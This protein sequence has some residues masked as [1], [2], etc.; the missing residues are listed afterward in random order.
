MTTTD[1]HGGQ[2]PMDMPVQPAAPQAAQPAAAPATR[3]ARRRTAQRK[4][5]PRSTV[6]L[7]AVA[8]TGAAAVIVTGLAVTAG[9]VAALA[10]A[11]GVPMTVAARMLTRGN[12]TPGRRTTTRRPGRRPGGKTPALK[13]PVMPKMR[14]AGGG[15][16]GTKTATRPPGSSKAGPRDAGS[17]PKKTAFASPGP[18]GAKTRSGPAGAGTGMPKVTGPRTP[19]DGARTPK[20]GARPAAGANP[21]RSSAGTP[22]VASKRTGANATRGG[23]PTG[24][25]RRPAQSSSSTPGTS[26]VR[27]VAE[28]RAARRATPA[29]PTRRAPQVTATHASGGVPDRPTRRGLRTP[30]TRVGHA[31]Q[32]KRL[33]DQEKYLAWFHNRP[34][35]VRQGTRRA[36]TG[37]GRAAKTAAVTTGRA[38]K[39]GFVGSAKPR[40]AAKSAYKAARAAKRPG[41]RGQVGSVAAGVVGAGLAA[42]ARGTTNRAKPVGRGAAKAGTAAA[43]RYRKVRRL[44]ARRTRNFGKRLLWVCTGN[45]EALNADRARAARRDALIAKLTADRKAASKAK[46]TV[47]RPQAQA[48]PVQPQQGQTPAATVQ[49][50]AGPVT[51]TNPRPQ[52][53]P[54]TPT[55]SV[56]TGL[57]GGTTMIPQ[58]PPYQAAVETAGH[59]FVWSPGS[60]DGAL[61]A[62]YDAMPKMRNTAHWIAH[63]WQVCF[64]AISQDLKGNLRPAQLKQQDQ[65]LRLMTQTIGVFDD[66]KRA[67]WTVHQRQLE[68]Y[69]MANGHV[70][71]VDSTARGEVNR[72]FPAWGK[73]EEYGKALARWRPSNNTVGGSGALFKYQ[74]ALPYMAKG[75]WMIANGW[76]EAMKNVG[77]ALRGGLDPAMSG[78]MTHIYRSFSSAASELD[79]LHQ[80][81]FRLHA[82]DTE[83]RQRP[84]ANTANVPVRR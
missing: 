14:P 20:G 75:Q 35:A 59:L 63:G 52:P 68:L 2:I 54:I 3:P 48:Q 21:N 61:F 16:A 18:S 45:T 19:K 74:D 8:G 39:A 71:N 58:F 29:A 60:G 62:F 32:Q 40:Q 77:E 43:K 69:G 1:G 51:T 36:L 41:V 72:N 9:P 7:A 22:G 28:R 37:T 56:G 53:T 12:R 27:R 13:T 6:A 10:A 55:P 83:R 17:P 23:A 42:A 67:F 25:G 44:A 70:S 50:P 47:P 84:G 81:F 76:Y 80:S 15:P 82:D 33:E 79:T 30:R 49:A 78:A 57:T 66:L 46:N 34:K 31:M 38:A 65:A 73:A 64:A 11:V 5:L 24:R 26:R 4:P